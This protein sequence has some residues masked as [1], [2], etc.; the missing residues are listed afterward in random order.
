MNIDYPLVSE[1]LSFL[2][3]RFQVERTPTGYIVSTPYLTPENDPLVVRVIDKGD[4]RLTFSDGGRVAEYL[5]LS[6]AELEA[7]ARRMA[8]AREIVASAGMQLSNGEIVKEVRP[9]EEA[10]AFHDTIRAMLGVY[11]LVYSALPGPLL[12]RMAPL[13]PRVHTRLRRDF[14]DWDIL[15]DIEENQTIQGAIPWVIDFS[16]TA[17]A[18]VLRVLIATVDLRVK[19]PLEK[20]KHLS[21]QWAD[22]RRVLPSLEANA[23]FRRPDADGDYRRAEDLITAL[24]DLSFDY[25]KQQE[26]FRSKV[27]DD[28]PVVGPLREKQLRF[29]R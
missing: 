8:L 18:K 1:Y 20:A 29:P 26:D 25:D 27:L 24:S 16:Y 21:A 5:F 14:T 17:S 4:G 11:S 9:G 28:R 3:S 10:E 2:A 22:L 7:S 13:G 15:P 23:V 6:G 12:A 19:S